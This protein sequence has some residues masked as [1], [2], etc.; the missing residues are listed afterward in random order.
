MDNR[1]TTW[2]VTI[3]NPTEKDE[4]EISLARQKGWKVEGQKE[5]GEEGTPHYQLLVKTPQV[6]FS[7]VKKAFS[8]AHIEVARNAPALHNYVTKTDTRVGQLQVQQDKYPSLS[9]LWVLVFEK[10]NALNYLDIDGYPNKLWK[11]CTGA[12]PI[13]ELFDDAI[14]LLIIEGYHVQSIAANPATRSMFKL[15]WQ[16]TFESIYLAQ[17]RAASLETKDRQTDNALESHVS[18]PTIEHNHA[19]DNS[20]TSPGLPQ[21]RRAAAYEDDESDSQSQGEVACSWN[22]GSSD[23]GREATDCEGTGEQD[24]WE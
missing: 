13:L 3:N 22:T 15:Y 24:D 6:R 11:R 21:A 4:E 19:N 14:R 2:S 1:A 16:A 8:R 7:A 12:R 20:G 5:K 9:K 23:S 17:E 10:F 18:V